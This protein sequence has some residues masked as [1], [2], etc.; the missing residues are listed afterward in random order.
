M[1]RSYSMDRDESLEDMHGMVPALDMSMLRSGSSELDRR[2]VKQ[3]S[4]TPTQS[5]EIQ[6]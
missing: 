4:Q 5:A 6:H 2:R 3:C 1:F